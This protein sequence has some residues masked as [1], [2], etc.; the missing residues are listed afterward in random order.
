MKLLAQVEEML[1]SL[2]LTVNIPE[3]YTSVYKYERDKPEVVAAEFIHPTIDDY[4]LYEK[5]ENNIPKGWYGFSIGNPTPKNWFIAID[6]ILE[7]LVQ[8]DPALEIH[9]IKMKFGC[10]CFY[11]ESS[12]IEDINE[13]SITVTTKLC[14]Q[15]LIY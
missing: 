1:N 4:F 14:N 6:K 15:K 9:Q 12:I 5:Y 3:D 2:D 7:L 13:I 10:I 11:I 8:H